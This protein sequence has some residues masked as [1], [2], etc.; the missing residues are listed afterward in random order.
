M[1]TITAQRKLLFCRWHRAGLLF[2]LFFAP[3]VDAELLGKREICYQPGLIAC[4]PTNTLRLITDAPSDILATALFPLTRARIGRTAVDFGV[5][6]AVLPFDRTLSP[7]IW[8]LSDWS[9]ERGMRPQT[10]RSWYVPGFLFYD[11]IMTYALPVI[12]VSAAA[13]NDDRLYRASLLGMKVWAYSILVP[14]PFRYFVQRSYPYDRDGRLNSP[15]DFHSG[16]DF[17]R[18]QSVLKGAGSFPSFRAAMWFGLADTF[19]YEYG[20]HAAWYSAASTLTLLADHRHWASDLVFGAFVGFSV[21]QSVR[22]LHFNDKPREL[23]LLPF[24]D[25]EIVGVTLSKTLD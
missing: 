23:I 20:Y 14:I 4:L 13:I 7:K 2:L 3:A 15:F 1:P 5:T 18:N 19:A 22:T 12:Y 6:F 17:D 9:G 10:P 21:S 8:Q 24:V 11:S 16:D 25:S